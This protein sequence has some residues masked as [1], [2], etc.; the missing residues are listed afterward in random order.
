M[1]STGFFELL[2]DPTF[3][4]TLAAAIFAFAT[5]V[6]LGLPLAGPRQSRPAPQGGVGTA[7]GIA[8]QAPC[9][10][11][12]QARLA[13]QRTGRL[14]EDDART[15][16]TSA[17]CW[18]PKTRATS[19]RAP[20]IAAR[21]PV[22]TFMFFRFVMPFVVFVLA[23]VYLFVDQPFGVE[24]DHEDQR[25]CRR[26]SA[27][28]LSARSVRQQHD[29]APPAIDHARLSRRARPAADLRGIGHVG[30]SVV[31]A[32]GVAKSALSRP[33]WPRNSA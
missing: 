23:L 18:N 7:R 14:H 16:S 29:R 10:A 28:L 27:R 21:R 22:V 11:E 24:H 2:F 17:I 6:T 33:S 5:I 20:A 9:G 4:A 1:L 3:L 19:W 13:A 26:C 12:R 30:R 32:R 31:P 15:A 25:L 8:R